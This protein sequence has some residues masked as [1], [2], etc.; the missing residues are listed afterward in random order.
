MGKYPMQVN[1]LVPMLFVSKRGTGS[2]ENVETFTHWSEHQDI[3]CQAS[4]GE[5]RKGNK[6]RETG[7]HAKESYA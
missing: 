5:K 3:Q 2:G 1:T 4:R 6:E 7:S